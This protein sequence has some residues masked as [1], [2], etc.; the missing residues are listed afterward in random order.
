MICKYFLLWT[1]VSSVCIA[2]PN[3]LPYAHHRSPDKGEKQLSY[4]LDFDPI[5]TNTLF[6]MHVS[7]IIRSGKPQKVAL[8][9]QLQNT[10]RRSVCKGNTITFQ[11]FGLLNRIRNELDDN[12]IESAT[13]RM[14]IDNAKMPSRPKSYISDYVNINTN[15]VETPRLGTHRTHA[16]AV[17]RRDPPKG[18]YKSKVPPRRSHA[19]AL[20]TLNLTTVGDPEMMNADALEAEWSQ[21]YATQSDATVS[22]GRGSGYSGSTDRSLDQH[23]IRN[24]TRSPTVSPTTPTPT[25]KPTHA[26]S[27]SIPYKKR[28]GSADTDETLHTPHSG[29][30]VLN[31]S[32]ISTDLQSPKHVHTQSYSLET[33]R[34]TSYSNTSESTNTTRVSTSPMHANNTEIGWMEEAEPQ[35]EHALSI[36]AMIQKHSRFVFGVGTFAV[37]VVCILLGLFFRDRICIAFYS[38][39]S[40]EALARQLTIQVDVDETL[41]DENEDAHDAYLVRQ[42]AI[43]RQDRKIREEWI[44]ATL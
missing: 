44:R 5:H 3:R 31:Y 15:C 24:P 10:Q 22:T 14:K 34:G 28:S 9:Y 40:K 23:L 20:P 7:T 17:P 8:L 30:N 25:V 21:Q 19:H 39:S 4:I 16:S 26:P 13:I 12:T 18:K 43:N 32:A 11:I 42:N 1:L 29:S 35:T 37:L 33:Q 27:L 36:G 38:Q 6:F 2:H 41:N